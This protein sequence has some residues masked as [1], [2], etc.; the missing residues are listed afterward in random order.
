MIE[1]F[2]R[3]HT[4]ARKPTRVLLLIGIGILLMFVV[5][6]LATRVRTFQIFPLR[7][8]VVMGNNILSTEE[9]LT[10]TGLSA[11]QSLLSIR[12]SVVLRKLLRDKRIASAEVIK[13]YPDKLKILLSEVPGRVLINMGKEVYVS[14]SDG[15]I[16]KK[17]DNSG[18]V[19]P[20]YKD[21]I[22]ITLNEKNVDIKVGDY[23]GSILTREAI[24]AFSGMK[25]K[26][27][28]IYRMIDRIVVESQGITVI[29]NRRAE[30][31]REVYL[32]FSIDSE[33][34]E[35]LRAVLL[36][37]KKIYG[38]TSSHV[39]IDLSSSY[40]AVKLEES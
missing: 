25:V 4:V 6:N 23:I 36:V 11:D 40:A 13:I 10:L 37:T 18:E 31:V 9:I 17:L 28:E 27:S 29:L 33:K 35:K 3:T 1:R 24:A 14:S 38:N 30:P 39:Y 5:I 8:V 19:N 2:G 20:H 32:G 7:S 26:S 22:E 21:F 12:K 15:L 16:L 34:L